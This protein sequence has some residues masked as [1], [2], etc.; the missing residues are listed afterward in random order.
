MTDKNTLAEIFK[1]LPHLDCGECGLKSCTEFA[2][3][4]MEG[5]DIT[6]CPHIKDEEMQAITLLLDEYYNL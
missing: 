1:N 6:K 5:E 3:A 2:K 4:L